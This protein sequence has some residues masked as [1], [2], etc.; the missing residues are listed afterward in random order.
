MTTLPADPFAYLENGDDP[1]TKEWTAGE[2]ARTRAALQALPGR[3]ALARRFDALLAIGSL[4][5]PVERGGRYFFMARDGRQNQAVLRVREDRVE[6]TLIDPAALD[7]SGLTALDWWYP[8]PNGTYVAYGLSRNGDERSTLYLL[9][10]ARGVAFGEEIPDTRYTALTWLRD[11][12]AFF[13]TRYPPGGEYGSKLY[14]HALGAD[15]RDDP[16]IFGEGRAPEEFLSATLSLDGRW[17]AVTANRGWAASDVYVADLRAAE[18][19]RFI[20]LAEGR[21]ALFDVRFRGDELLIRSNEGAPRYRLLSVPAASPVLDGARIVVEEDPEATLEDFAVA[22]GG[23]ALAYLRDVSAQIE[24]S[25]EDGTRNRLRADS[26]T[27]ASGPF[28]V[29]GLSAREDSPNVFVLA[30]SYL[31]PPRVSQLTLIRNGDVRALATTTWAEIASPLRA[32][33]YTVVQHWIASKDGTRVPMFVIANAATPL[34]GTAPA[35]LHG[36][37]GFNVSLTP[38]FQPSLVP[39]LDAGGVYAIANLRGGGEFGEA[40]HRAGMLENKQN[41]FDDFIAAAEYLG[42]AKI[43]DPKRIGIVGGSNGGLLVAAAE[44]QRP[45]LFAAVICAVPLTDMLIYQKFLIARLWIAEYGDPENPAAAAWLSAYS[46]Y[47]N[48]RDGVAY[49][50]TYVVT[51]ESDT[52]VDPCHARK[53]AA[54]L[55]QASSSGAPVLLYVEP[56]AGHGIGKPR[57]KQLEELVDRWSFF[58]AH[59]GIDWPF[60]G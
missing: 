22:R 44:T 11:E 19:Y 43:A 45:D 7:P 46:P 3:D 58:G 59:L 2:N 57:A 1:R 29:M 9:D 25:Y 48:V 42:S 35:V 54:R 51:A 50:P 38:S 52:R 40:W 26:L 53:F 14:L 49:P 13:Y 24:L 23:I 5:L 32:A 20:A 12:R 47:Q 55:R 16:L 60:S 10:T 36:Y 33:D 6:R 31:Q 15:W 56:N 39:W 28:S 8:S 34:D 21:D 18:P 37:G 30:V 4:G 17:L 27:D 41:V